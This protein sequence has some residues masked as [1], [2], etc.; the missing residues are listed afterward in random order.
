MTIFGND[1]ML[2]EKLSKFFVSEMG[3]TQKWQ[4]AAVIF[5]LKNTQ[6]DRNTE[7]ALHDII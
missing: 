3:K 7:A 2:C 1:K 5:F 6:N 4:M